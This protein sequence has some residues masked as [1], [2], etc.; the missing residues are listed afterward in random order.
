[1]TQPVAPEPLRLPSGS[2]AALDVFVDSA[3]ESRVRTGHAPPRDAE[4][5]TLLGQADGVF[6][7]HL[8]L[9]GREP[10]TVKLRWWAARKHWKPH[11][12]CSDFRAFRMC[13]HLGPAAIALRRLVP[14]AAGDPAARAPRS[15]FAREVADR[16]GRRLTPAEWKRLDELRACHQRYLERGTLGEWDLARAGWMPYHTTFPPQALPQGL[17]LSEQDFWLC[18]SLELRRQNIPLPDFMTA[19]SDPARASPALL[20][21]FAVRRRRAWAADLEKAEIASQGERQAAPAEFRLRVTAEGLEF[22]CRTPL[23][24]NFHGPHLPRGAPAAELNRWMAGWVGESPLPPE[25]SLA[26]RMMQ[27][28][29]FDARHTLSWRS[30]PDL[31]IFS[32]LAS[33]TDLRRHL[34]DEE[35]EPLIFHSQPL[36]WRLVEPDAP[37]QPYRFEL[38]T[39]DGQPFT[40]VIHAVAPARPAW[41]ICAEGI[42]AGPV[43]LPRRTGYQVAVPAEVAESAIGLR[44]ARRAGV[45]AP[46]AIVAKVRVA[47]VPVRVEIR[48]AGI[49]GRKTK[50]RLLLEAVVLGPGDVALERLAESRWRRLPGI[51]A[52]A[53][54]DFVLADRRLAEATAAW[55][56]DSGFAWEPGENLW[57]RPVAGEDFASDLHHWLRAAPVGLDLRLAGAVQSLLDGI[58]AVDLAVEATPVAEDGRSDWFDLKLRSEWP[59]HGL[60]PEEV[61]LLRAAS[62]RWVRLPDKGW[63]RLEVTADDTVAALARLGLDPADTDGPPRRVHALQLAGGPAQLIPADIAELVS[64]RAEEIA[65]RVTPPPPPGLQAELR[66]YQVEGFHFLAY[67]AANRFGGVLADDMGLGKTV[68]TLAWLL[69]L[70][71]EAG[72]EAGPTLVVCPKSVMENWREECVRFAP[73]LRAR[74][75]RAAE[76]EDFRPLGTDADLHIINYTHLRLI[77]GRWPTTPFLAVVADEAQAIKNPDSDS[78]RALCAVPARHRLALTGTPIE[79]RLLDLWAILAFAMPGLLGSRSEFQ[80]RHGP[81]ADAHARVRLAARVR[82]FLLRRTKAQVAPDLPARIEED[83]HCDLEGTQRRLYEAEL[84]RARSIL[85]RLR[86][87]EDLD[88]ERFNILASLTRLRQI[89]CDPRLIL[90]EDAQEGA[91]MELLRGQ[92]ETLIEEGQK[93]L[94]FSQ[95]TS[96]LD[97]IQPALAATFP[98]VPVF[99]LDG[100]TE[101]RGALVEAFQATEGAALFLLSLKAGGTGLNLTAA[102][103]VI[104]CDPWWNPA[105]ENQAIDRTHR[106]GQASQVIAYR[107]VARDTVEEKIRNLQA[108]KRALA[109]DVLGEER[110]ARSLDLD[111]FRFLLGEGG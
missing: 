65:L 51:A 63:R 54:D 60:T 85:L 96:F 68:Q 105:V 83:L 28:D 59:A 82:P 106:I 36:S 24:E 30:G 86:T 88:E 2:A 84:K 12:S 22:E 110:F 99:R 19:V 32:R 45:E 3:A 26:L 70:R 40:G 53:Q 66:P 98:G 47:P 46:P 5:A 58:I 23:H 56:A 20:E 73:E 37:G 109:Q 69:H 41:Y 13:A 8:P 64:R 33:I 111:D 108:G 74:V 103:Y 61:D 79:N 14:P 35:G 29:V 91:K 16:A 38:I 43:D 93:V 55:V 10:V 101:N 39:A 7:L 80:R 89:C 102:S 11:C 77:E 67:L 9:A 57:R 90:P 44:L 81:R 75:W 92:V 104:L 100:A 97:L 87:G 49:P 31:E 42:Y 27:L 25:G 18:V 48:L 78:H 50:E 95:F 17:P 34:V 52:E 1:M 72:P 6:T 71:A 4:E 94:V 107:L 21:F 15:S 62:G 76:A